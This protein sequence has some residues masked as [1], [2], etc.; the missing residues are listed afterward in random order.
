MAEERADR[1][2]RPAILMELVG[3]G[4][5][6][7]F[8]SE[9]GLGRSLYPDHPLRSIAFR[10]PRYTLARFDWDC[11]AAVVLPADYADLA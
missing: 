2:D 8:A 1:A 4:S 11:E 5:R 3:D 9:S 7:G 6:G 10:G